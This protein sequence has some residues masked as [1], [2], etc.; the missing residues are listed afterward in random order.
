MRRSG[1]IAAV[2]ILGLLISCS[3]PLQDRTI[4]PLSYRTRDPK[5]SEVSDREKEILFTRDDREIPGKVFYP[6]EGGTCPVVLMSGGLG[7]RYSE[8][9]NKA[10][11]FSDRGYVAVVF[12]FVSNMDS[13]SKDLLVRD[14]DISGLLAS[15]VKDLAAVLDSLP[16]IPGADTSRVYLWGHSYGGLVSSYVGTRRADLILGLIL[17]EPAILKDP[18]S[19]VPGDPATKVDILKDLGSSDLDTLIFAG[20]TS[21]YGADPHAY[22]PVMSVL[23]HGERV[24]I[25][26]ASHDFSG[27]YGEEMVDRSCEFMAS[28]R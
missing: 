8:Y 10:R 21:R 11:R 14:Q 13:S 9:E 25:D 23:K 7:S 5:I 18:G 20:T 17:A 19:L 6:E 24:I 1:V 4:G 28:R 16:K 2:L 15:Q 22:D 26:G 3:K 12:D 27:R